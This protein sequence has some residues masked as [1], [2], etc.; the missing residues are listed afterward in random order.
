MNRKQTKNKKYKAWRSSVYKRDGYKCVACLQKGYLNA[1]HLDGWNWCVERRYDVT[2]G[3]TLCWRCHAAFH[4]QYGRGDNTSFQ[5]EA[6]LWNYDRT[7][8]D[9]NL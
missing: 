2:N 8:G 7:L 9:L 6:F 5:F 3:V 4:R 1:H